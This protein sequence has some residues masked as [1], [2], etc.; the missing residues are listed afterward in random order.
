MTSAPSA[1]DRAPRE[2]INR[3][4]KNFQKT[5]DAPA[6]LLLRGKQRAPGDGVVVEA[7]NGGGAVTC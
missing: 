6:E 4:E 1:S 3:R 7:S 2:A 5:P